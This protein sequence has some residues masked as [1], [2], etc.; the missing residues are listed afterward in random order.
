MYNSL[1]NNVLS[2]T[3]ANKESRLSLRLFSYFT[4]H[5]SIWWLYQ[6]IN[7]ICNW[8]C[9]RIKHDC[10][11]SVI[12]YVNNLNYL[13]YGNNAV[14]DYRHAGMAYAT[15]LLT[16]ETTQ[17]MVISTRATYGRSNGISGTFPVKGHLRVYPCTRTNWYRHESLLVVAF[18]WNMLCN[19]FYKKNKRI[20]LRLESIICLKTPVVAK[21]EI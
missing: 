16:V 17:N 10:V 5:Y 1:G 8:K 14:T 13:N 9:N 12:M 11:L 19:Q 21:F 15:N 18:L 2:Y 3:A 7:I 4:K 20:R 6:C